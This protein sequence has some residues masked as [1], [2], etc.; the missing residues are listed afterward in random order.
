MATTERTRLR[1]RPARRS[2]MARLRIGPALA[3]GAGASGAS[4]PFPGIAFPR[5]QGRLARGVSGLLAILLHGGLF[6]AI[7]L[8]AT[9]APE[10][11]LEELIPVQLL[12]EVAA[13]VEEPAP[14][15]KALAERRSVNFAP[16]AQAIA[17][18]VINP[19]VV[20]RASPS[21]A[22]EKL[23]LDTV[24]PLTAPKRIERA[25]V[26]VETVQ[27]V[28]SVAG[29]EPRQLDVADAA[30]PA[31]RG[32]IEP[33]APVGPSA[34]PRQVVAEG[35]SIGT[36]R[37]V[38][39]DTSSVREGI[40][41][42]RDVLGSPTGP[43]LASVNTRVGEGYL[44]G[45]GGTG[46]GVGGVAPDCFERPE[47]KTYWSGI[48][49]RM[50]A[51][52]ALPP[53]LPQGTVEVKLRFRLDAAGS[54][55]RVELLPGGDPTLGQSAVDALRSASPFPPMSD[56]VRCLAGRRI[57]GVFRKRPGG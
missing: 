18:Q 40:Q 9:L 34:G 22:A 1:R 20:Q 28:T 32:P 57:T 44:R 3:A 15:P 41:S 8:A 25:A 4:L 30:S 31:L 13:P 38:V 55:T 14:A 26:A 42:N 10:E 43:R 11:E 27:A 33:V 5:P 50:Y 19:R 56:T 45:T 35:T 46:S 51:R 29:V 39:G 2:P 36:G 7:L 49:E 48:Q 23:E 6:A 54:A 12:R 47:V 52:W 53:N 21:V 24:G 37:V 16:S 17:P